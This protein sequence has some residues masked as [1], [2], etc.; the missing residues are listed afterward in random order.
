MQKSL[1]DYHFD[2]KR[3]G[4]IL[5]KWAKESGLSYSEIAEQTG[6]SPD[7]INNSLSGKIKELSLERV[8]KIA[9]LTGHSVCEFLRLMLDGEEIDF[10]DQIHVLTDKPLHM[11]KYKDTLPQEKA[12]AAVLPEHHTDDATLDRFRRVHGDYAA[13]IRDQTQQQLETMERQHKIHNDTMEKY[14]QQHIHTLEEKH[15]E[16]TEQLERENAR[17]RRRSTWLS[18]ALIIETLAV[19][20]ITIYDVINLDVGWYRGIMYPGGAESIHDALRG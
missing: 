12:P 19:M 7:T 9:V 14:H 8:F 6:Y 16:V 18:I 1:Q 10:A 5:K 15:K 13:A 20:V 17:L 3:S 4:E 2:P 11:V